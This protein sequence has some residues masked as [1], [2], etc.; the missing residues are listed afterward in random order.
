M[1]WMIKKGE[2]ITE[3][4][5][6]VTDISQVWFAGDNKKDLLVLYACSEND[7]PMYKH[8]HSESCLLQRLPGMTLTLLGIEPIGELH[9]DFEDLDFGALPT[10]IIDGRR[11]YYVTYSV[12]IHMGH[13][14]GALV[15]K[16]VSK[17][18]AIGKATLNFNEVEANVKGSS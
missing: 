11:A 6:L 8:D 18:E 3:Q 12:E 14:S 9:Y 13:K 1:K 7:P 10:K 15:Y 2:Y 17:G 16:V 5:K 4:T